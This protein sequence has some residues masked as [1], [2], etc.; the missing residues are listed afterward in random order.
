MEKTKKEQAIKKLHAELKE[1]KV[2]ELQRCATSPVSL[3]RPPSF[4][5]HPSG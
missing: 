1:E 5:Q 4:L 2:A 3:R